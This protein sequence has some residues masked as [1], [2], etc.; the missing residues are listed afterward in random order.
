MLG[1]LRKYN[2]TQLCSGHNNFDTMYVW[3]PNVC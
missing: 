2:D 1:F 3:D